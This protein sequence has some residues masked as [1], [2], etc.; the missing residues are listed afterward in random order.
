MRNQQSLEESQK[1]AIPEFM[2]HNIVENE[3]RNVI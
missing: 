3:V 2:R 1:T